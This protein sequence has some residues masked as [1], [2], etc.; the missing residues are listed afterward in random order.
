MSNAFPYLPKLGPLVTGAHSTDTL[1]STSLNNGS[2][3]VNLGGDLGLL[4]AASPSAQA[5]WD[6]AA[7]HAG[8]D[9]GSSADDMGWGGAGSG[10]PALTVRAPAAG[11]GP[12]APGNSGADAAGHAGT[13]PGTASADTEK[14]FWQKAGDFLTNPHT[15][16]GAA[17]FALSVF[18]SA[19][20]AADG[21]LYGLQGKYADAGLSLSAAAVG[22][23]SDAGAA[24]LA[25]E[26]VKAGAEAL[27]AG[28]AGEAAVQEFAGLDG[29]TTAQLALLPNQIERWT[30]NA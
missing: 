9:Q 1:D 17:S 30:G 2:G 13:A 14:S 29:R 28:R 19:A 11:D 6:Q 15:V 16:L 27:T 25:A 21:L 26:G 23:V 12:A 3:T 8:L 20:S 5:T 18:G 7:A 24:R 4:G 10:V 22:M